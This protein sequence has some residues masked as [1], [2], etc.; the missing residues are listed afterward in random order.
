MEEVKRRLAAEMTQ[1]HG[2]HENDAV[3]LGEGPGWRER[4]YKVKLDA[5]D[6]AVKEVCRE[7]WRGLQWVL[8]YYYSGCASWVYYYERHYAPFACDLAAYAPL[9]PPFWDKKAAGEPFKPLAQL[10]AVIPPGS[11]HCLPE[12]C[13]LVMGLDVEHASDDVRAAAATARGLVGKRGLELMFP[14]KIK[15]DPNGRKH[16]WEWVALLPFLDERKLTTVIDAVAATF[17][18]GK[19]AR[20]TTRLGLAAG[21]GHARP[22]FPVAFL[23]LSKLPDEPPYLAFPE[24]ADLAPHLCRPVGPSPDTSEGGLTG[25][26]GRERDAVW[27]PGEAAGKM[28]DTGEARKHPRMRLADLQSAGRMIRYHAGQDQRHAAMAAAPRRSARQR[29]RRRAAPAAA[30]PP[31]RRPAAVPA[32]GP[33]PAPGPVPPQGQFQGQHQFPASPTASSSSAAPL[34]SPPSG[35]ASARMRRPSF[36]RP[37]NGGLARTRRRTRFAA[38]AARVDGGELGRGREP[39]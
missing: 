11:A 4:Y 24:P 23:N 35:G 6:R 39:A 3:G 5:D 14:T 33:V 10:L 36:S 25:C 2:S 37:P 16:Q 20:N 26:E 31:V 22:P 32:A 17:D 12:A 30:A 18:D 15:M 34:V 13:R 38:A 1:K 21:A 27:K 8:S 19:R 7:Y 28:R 9:C 29:L